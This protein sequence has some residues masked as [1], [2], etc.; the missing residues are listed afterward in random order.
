MLLTDI[1]QSPCGTFAPLSVSF[2]NLSLTKVLAK[3]SGATQTPV[4]VGE[5]IPLPNKP[6]SQRFWIRTNI[7]A[8]V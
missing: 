4:L 7:V 5:R 6:H 2:L 8:F 3:E 1:T